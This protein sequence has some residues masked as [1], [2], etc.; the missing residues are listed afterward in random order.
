MRGRFRV[1]EQDNLLGLRGVIEARPCHRPTNILARRSGTTPTSGIYT[2]EAATPFTPRQRRPFHPIHHM[3]DGNDRFAWACRVL[4]V[5]L[6]HAVGRDEG[7]AENSRPCRHPRSSCCRSQ[8]SRRM[9]PWCRRLRMT[10]GPKRTGRP[11]PRRRG[12]TRCRAHAAER[13]LFGNWM[14]AII[15]KNNRLALS[16]PGPLEIGNRVLRL[17]DRDCSAEE[18]Q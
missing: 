3:T 9:V 17:G 4:G 12:S 7:N 13:S 1:T 15:A 8:S 5:A 10:N 18:H 2:V 11:D 16:R 14:V 6:L